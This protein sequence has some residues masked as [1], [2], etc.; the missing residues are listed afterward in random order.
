[1]ARVLEYYIEV[2]GREWKRR[3]SGREGVGEGREWK[4]EWEWEM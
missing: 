2:E 1:M 4:S 3:W